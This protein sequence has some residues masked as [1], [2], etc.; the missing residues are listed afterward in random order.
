MV[1]DNTLEAFDLLMEEIENLL[2]S[3]RN[4]GAEAYR[5][6]ETVI[7]QETDKI[8]KFLEELRKTVDELRYKTFSFLQVPLKDPKLEKEARNQK[9][10]SRTPEKEPHKRFALDATPTHVYRFLILE[11]LFEMGGK[12][13]SKEVER[14]IEE[15]MRQYFRPDDLRPVSSGQIR[16]RKRLHW[17]RYFMVKDGLLRDDTP[18]GIWEI[19]NQGRQELLKSRKQFS[20][21]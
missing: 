1:Y 10:N 11:T 14:K 16:W 20:R 4:E 9:A 19:T 18:R 5:K 13:F 6:G 8:V 21:K 7:F 17:C 12:A 15:K 3:K 2:E